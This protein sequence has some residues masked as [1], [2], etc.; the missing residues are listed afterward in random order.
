MPAC[1]VSKTVSKRGKTAWENGG[2]NGVR[3][4]IE[5]PWFSGCLILPSRPVTPDAVLGTARRRGG[6]FAQG[7]I[8]GQQGKIEG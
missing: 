7:K 2:E 6:L 3:H 1:G 5:F 4:E 8:F